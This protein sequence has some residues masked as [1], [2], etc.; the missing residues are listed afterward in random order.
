MWGFLTFFVPFLFFYSIFGVWFLRA[1]FEHSLSVM[2][3][4]KQYPSHTMSQFF[5]KTSMKC[6]MGR[7]R[8][9]WGFLTFFVPFLILSIF[10]VWFFRA[11]FEHPLIVVN[12]FKLYR[13][14]TKSQNYFKTSKKWKMSQG[15]KNGT[16][17][18]ILRTLSNF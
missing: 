15:M 5:F 8:R 16:I 14:H 3:S 6:I 9:M 13:N 1:S 10:G 18:H 2:N 11:S 4:F 12:S 7:V 17:S